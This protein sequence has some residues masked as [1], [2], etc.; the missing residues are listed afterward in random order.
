MPFS[1]LIPQNKLKAYTREQ[2]E[3]HRLYMRTDG[4]VYVYKLKED[5]YIVF[6]VDEP[7]WMELTPHRHL[8]GS[9]RPAPEGTKIVLT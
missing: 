8:S 3:L 6:D 9:Y 7:E 1:L 5:A 2:L 4:K